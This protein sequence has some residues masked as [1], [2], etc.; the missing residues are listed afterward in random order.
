[1]LDGFNLIHF[2][3]SFVFGGTVTSFETLDGLCLPD[4]L[5]ANG[6][7]ANSYRTRDGNATKGRW[8]T[9]IAIQKEL[10]HFTSQAAPL[11]KHVQVSKLN[12][13]K[14]LTAA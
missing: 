8:I 12:N 10:S 14:F 3:S 6:L 11:Q 2:E 4:G 5:A 7:V 1:M 9:T 13:F